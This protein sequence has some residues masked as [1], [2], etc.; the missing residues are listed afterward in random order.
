MIGGTSSLLD[1]TFLANA[2]TSNVVLTVT[3]RV[4]IDTA[5]VLENPNKEA[6][7]FYLTNGDYIIVTV[8]PDGTNKDTGCTI[9]WSEEV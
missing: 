4:E 1:T 8:R 5:L 6:S 9:E 7:P 3:R 2:T